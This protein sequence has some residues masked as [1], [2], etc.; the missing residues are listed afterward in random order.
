MFSGPNWTEKKEK[1]L[2]VDFWVLCHWVILSNIINTASQTS[3]SKGIIA[4]KWK[5]DIF[6]CRKNFGNNFP[7]TFRRKGIPNFSLCLWRFLLNMFNTGLYYQLLPFSVKSLT[8]VIQFVVSRTV[9]I[10]CFFSICS[11][12][13]P[14]VIPTHFYCTVSGLKSNVFYELEHLSASNIS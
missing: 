7:P 3:I 8:D 13:P 1:C 10:F 11:I 9:H 4:R 2:K 5:E 6:R 14:T 12:V